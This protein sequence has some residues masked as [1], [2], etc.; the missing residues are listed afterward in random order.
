[1]DAVAQIEIYRLEFDSTGFDLGEIQNVVHD[2]QQRL[3]RVLDRANEPFP[4][5]V[6][7]GIQQQFRHADNR[8]HRRAYLV[9]HLC[10]EIA[11]CD[12]CLVRQF[13]GLFKFS[14][15]G[16]ERGAVLDGLP[17]VG[18]AGAWIQSGERA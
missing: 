4:L 14:R 10:Q 2:F 18:A 6:E 7:L 8:V 9:A 11:L 5:R 15:L 16:P 17:V 1:M 12:R 13:L 3:G